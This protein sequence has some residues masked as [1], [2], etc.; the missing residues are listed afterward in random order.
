MWFLQSFLSCRAV[1]PKHRD[2]NERNPSISIAS[3]IP[4]TSTS[5]IVHSVSTSSASSSAG[6]SPTPGAGPSSS[7][8][9]QHCEDESGSG[10]NSGDEYG[11]G[12][13]SS[14]IGISEEEWEQVLIW[15]HH[16]YLYIYFKCI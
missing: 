16:N 12:R 13:S 14:N 1:R 6:S 5:G 9:H 15:T 8:S 7:Y 4:G 2:R 10:Y 11:P 3:A